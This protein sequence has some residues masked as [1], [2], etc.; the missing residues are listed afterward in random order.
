MIATC[1][2]PRRA[3]ACCVER[4]AQRPHERCSTSWSACPTSR[5]LSA[6]RAA[7][8]R[9]VGHPRLCSARATREL[10]HEASHRDPWYIPLED[11]LDQITPARERVLERPRDAERPA[12]AGQPAHDDDRGADP[13]REYAERARLPDHDPPR[14]VRRRA[15]RGHSSAGAMSTIAK[16]E[17]IGF[18]APRLVG[19][20]LD[21]PR[22]RRARVARALPA[23]GRPTTRSSNCYCGVGVR[24]DRADAR[25]GDRRQRRRRRRVGEL[26]EHAREPQVRGAAA[27]DV[28]RRRDGDQ[29]PRHA[30]ARDASAAPARSARPT[31]SARIEV[32][33]ARRLLPLRPGPPQHDAR[34]RPD[35]GGRR[36][37]R[38]CRATSSPAT[39]T[40]EVRRMLEALPRGEEAGARRGEAGRHRVVVLDADEAGDRDTVRR[41]GLVDRPRRRHGLLEEPFSGTDGQV[42][43]EPGMTFYIEPMIVPTRIGTFASR[44]SSSSPRPYRG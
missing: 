17:E 20:A 3:L 27:E 15:H 40:D 16:L 38:T 11:A 26:P 6:R 4:H 33:T 18:L 42:L 7:R 25:D 44:T 21:D 24:A 2:H 36:Y 32:G 9:G 34:A 23:L 30:E 5:R 22:R 31:C 28:L 41:V 39:S 29:R 8:L 12:R 19:R 37:R 14:R 43:F 13:R 1:G 10:H 35:L